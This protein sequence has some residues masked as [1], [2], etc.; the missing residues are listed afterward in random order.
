M[1]A[2]IN[3]K[4]VLLHFDS[5]KASHFLFQNPLVT[6]V[7]SY[8]ESRGFSKLF[9]PTTEIVVF[10][11]R[12]FIKKYMSEAITMEDLDFVEPLVLAHGLPFNRKGWERVVTV[13][14]GF[15]P[16]EIQALPEGTVIPTRIP[17]VQ[18]RSLD[19]E[20]AWL[21]S[22]IET[23]LLR[24]IWYPTTV[25]TVSREVKKIILK[26][27]EES[28]DL[29]DGADFKLHDFGG[30]GVSSGE[31]AA[32]GGLAHL[33]NFM[34]TDTFE[35]IIAHQE[36]YHGDMPA[37]AVKATEHSVSTQFGPGLGESEYVSKVLD[38]AEANPGT[39]TSIVADTYD[40]YNFVDV[41]IGQDFASRIAKLDGVLVIRPDSGVPA[42]VVVNILNILGRRFGF[43]TNAKGYRVLPDFIRVIQGDG[44]NLNSLSE[45]VGAVLNEGWSIVNITFGMGGGLLQ[46]VTRDDLKFAQKANEAVID[47]VV[48]DTFKDPKT[49]PGKVSKK[50]RQFVIHDDTGWDS[51]REDLAVPFQVNQL[52]VVYSHGN[53]Y[54]I[55]NRTT[56]D[57]NEIRERA[58]V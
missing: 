37:Y 3:K 41:I 51:I 7:S 54:S 46:Q 53:G 50:G 27:Y 33:V 23:A 14:G 26:A 11:I 58:K 39:I 42:E 16:I 17:L 28:A 29:L 12:M 55:W 44:I 19:P 8:I 52:E 15:L 10:G 6:E 31:S 40:L 9:K 13:H 32:I 30:R 18:V 48:T 38:V 20:L 47:D 57:F 24:A 4:T 25:A 49:D 56:A 45:V 35:S 21:S 34:G 36:F 2:I 5:Y 22:F 1:N 43:V